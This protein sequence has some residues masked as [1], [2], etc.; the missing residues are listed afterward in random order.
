MADRAIDLEGLRR[1]DFVAVSSSGGI[2]SAAALLVAV[3]SCRA[4]GVSLD[5]VVVIHADMGRM[6]WPSA[7]SLGQVAADG[8]D[9]RHSTDLARAQAESLGLRFEVCRRNQGDLLEQMGREG[10]SLPRRRDELSGDLG[11]QARPDLDGLHRARQRV[12]GGDGRDAAVSDRR[13]RR[14]GRPRKRRPRDDDREREPMPGPP[15][16]LDRERPGLERSPRGDDLVAAR[17]RD[18]KRALGNGSRRDPLRFPR[19]LVGLRRRPPAA[20]LLVLRVR[21]ARRLEPRRAA[22]SDALRRVCRSRK[23]LRATLELAFHIGRRGRR[24]GRRPRR[25]RRRGVGA[26]RRRRRVEFSRQYRRANRK[27]ENTMASE[28]ATEAT[29]ERIRQLWRSL[30]A[31]AAPELLAI[32]FRDLSEQ[33]RAELARHLV[34]DDLGDAEDLSD[35]IR[36]IADP[37]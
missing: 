16:V 2:D 36:A 7:E 3:D 22:T 15:G 11:S 32:L 29:V 6:E 33:N 37:D 25:R 26:I 20:V 5:R 24:P 17:A 31:E 21:S 9:A 8:F 27:D 28:R 19:A 34:N 35:Q 23:E 14:P 30:A 18:Q 12:S 10:N 4:A 1:A 13:G